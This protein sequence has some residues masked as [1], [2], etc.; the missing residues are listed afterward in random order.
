MNTSH[1]ARISVLLA[2]CSTLL[3]PSA[4][5]AIS[6]DGAPQ[7]L[8]STSG[9]QCIRSPDVTFE[10][11]SY[12]VAFVQGP[13]SGSGTHAVM[14][15]RWNP[16]EPSG[17]APT[18]VWSQTL[19]EPR[20]AASVRVA[21]VAGVITVVSVDRAA[22]VH[23]IRTDFFTTT[24]SRPMTMTPSSVG[25]SGT[26]LQHSLDCAT[27]G[28][29]PCVLSTLEVPV[30]S[31]TPQPFAYFAPGTA[32]RV[33]LGGRTDV[34][35]AIASVAGAPGQS[36]AVFVT[37]STSITAPQVMVAT[38]PAAATVQLGASTEPALSGIAAMIVQGAG[39]AFWTVGNFLVF[40]TRPTWMGAM[41]L[42][43]GRAMITGAQ[44]YFFIED[45]TPVGN[46]AVLVGRNSSTVANSEA[47]PIALTS[48]VPENGLMNVPSVLLA[49]MSRSPTR[50]AAGRNHCPLFGTAVAVYANGTST[51][52]DLLLQRLACSMNSECVDSANTVG[53]CVANRCIFPVGTTC[54][55]VA[56]AG[57]DAGRDA[58]SDANTIRDTGVVDTGA[59]DSSGPIMDA[60]ANNDSGVVSPIDVI[61][62]DVVV[63][64]MDASGAPDAMS[65]GDASVSPDGSSISSVTGGACGCRVG[66]ARSRDARPL[67]LGALV[68]LAALARRRRAR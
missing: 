57:V 28:M 10:G 15:G 61:A 17:F 50:I 24:L 39:A 36:A 56:D 18:T 46:N 35:I 2:S 43:S 29:P 16:A 63:P 1:L 30:G 55:A 52:S 45:G 8:V 51:S 66:A 68:V 40:A 62:D 23:Q 22:T 49:V 53:T 65:A 26:V 31:S 41:S 21:S 27:G 11:D 4:S 54:N 47:A 14:I 44:A 12:Y 64:S 33:V 7:R 6:L 32:T 20:L 60:S 42:V 13:C 3:V 5:H 34:P 38:A 25:S 59:R 67:A 48:F 19:D 58:A 9:G 37:N